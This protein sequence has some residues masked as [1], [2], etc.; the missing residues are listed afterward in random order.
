MRAIC[1]PPGAAAG[2]TEMCTCE[3]ALDRS[4]LMEDPPGPMRPPTNS[5]GTCNSLGGPGAAFGTALDCAPGGSGGGRPPAAG[6]PASAGVPAGRACIPAPGRAG[7]PG[8]AGCRGGPPMGHP[9]WARVSLI[10]CS[11]FS[12]SP[13]IV[14][15]PKASEGRW[16]I[17]T[18]APLRWRM[19]WMVSP[20][21]PMSARIWIP[22]NLSTL[23]LE[24]S[25]PGG[26]LGSARGIR[27][28][29][30]SGTL[31]G[32]PSWSHLDFFLFVASPADPLS[33]DDGG[34]AGNGAKL[35]PARMGMD[36]GEMARLCAAPLRRLRLRR[37]L[38]LRR[39]RL[40]LRRRLLR[41][42]LRL[43]L[44]CL[45]LRLRCLLALRRFLLALR[46]L[47]LRLRSF[48]SLLRLRSFSFSFSFSLSFSFSFCRS[49]SRSRS[50][51]FSLSF[52]FSFSSR[53]GGG[54]RCR[55]L[56][57]LTFSR[58]LV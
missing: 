20:P 29:S 17:L 28:W 2:S 14:T 12:T 55:S 36:S 44:R 38:P 37:R 53:L 39:L 8:S 31:P 35:P 43:A 57:S 30:Q 21:L 18:S 5:A 50:F 49:R 24:G 3:P 47:R 25:T 16:S 10:I 4:S 58:I 40:P 56:R 46:R 13:T 41:L 32:S 45:R 22:S 51:S 23:N 27:S 33:P 11:V 48:F 1:G 54:A 42:L 6:M 34:S 19:S 26:G 9:F 7:P 52:S 15:L